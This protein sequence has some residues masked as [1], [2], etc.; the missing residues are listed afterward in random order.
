MKQ[1]LLR[2]AKKIINSA[3]NKLLHSWG[4]IQNSKRQ[5]PNFLI[6]GTQK[7]GT[8]SLFFYLKFHPEIIRPIKKEIHFFNIHYGK[9]LAWY[10]AHFPLRSK[11]HITGEASPDYMFHP[12]TPQ[13]VKD[14]NPEMK[15]IFLLRNPIDRAYSAYQMNRR[16][17]IDP[18]ESF[19]EAIDF[20]LSNR[21][22]IGNQY[23]YERH[24]YF[25]LE[26]GLY[27]RQLNNWLLTF[28]K[29]QILVIKSEDFFQKT[30][31]ELKRVYRF[32]NIDSVLPNRL[33]PMNVGKYPPLSENVY[34]TLVDFYKEDLSLVRTHFDIDFDLHEKNFDG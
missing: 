10:K 12:E 3:R 24:N 14:L 4:Y 5:T 2:K 22:S 21:D 28:T 26:R 34:N 32:L 31:T 29:D 30:E 19:E 13:R 8:S 11:N 16:M 23:N 33:T 9:G 1:V 15:I 25:Y 7:G 6:V 20:E 27:G 18:R 17:K